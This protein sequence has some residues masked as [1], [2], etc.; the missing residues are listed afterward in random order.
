MTAPSGDTAPA[1][2]REW[3]HEHL[4]PPARRRA[5]PRRN[6]DPGGGAGR[7]ARG[8]RPGAQRHSGLGRR[9]G[10]DPGAGLHARLRVRGRR[11][12]GR[13]A[14]WRGSRLPGR[15]RH[16]PR[17]GHRSAQPARRGRA[18][19]DRLR[20]EDAR[21]HGRLRGQR[22]DG[23]RQRRVRARRGAALQ[24]AARASGGAPAWA[25][26]WCC[27]GKPWEGRG[28][29]GELGHVV[30]KIGGAHCT[31]GRRGCL[32]AYAGRGAMEIRAR[33]LHKRGRKTDLFKIMEKRGRD[34]GS[35]RACGRARSMPATSWRPS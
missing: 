27:G 5:R 24:V 3:R 26:A 6:E 11:R 31:C 10:R 18:D 32:E 9:P 14:G 22:R 21:R 8:D 15:D 34:R 1:G 2:G 13:G 30:V 28:A 33:R 17:R 20:H 7:P 19:P 12:G 29:A 4:S 16:P 23:R 35:R 25:A